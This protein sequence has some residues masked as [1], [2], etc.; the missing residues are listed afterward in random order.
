MSKK[1]FSKAEIDRLIAEKNKQAPQWAVDAI[2][3]Y[4]LRKKYGLMRIE[5]GPGYAPADYYTGFAPG[6][7]ENDAP[8]PVT[9]LRREQD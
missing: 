2:E 6:I 4:K 8:A 5:T 9:P 7:Y 3:D 1:P